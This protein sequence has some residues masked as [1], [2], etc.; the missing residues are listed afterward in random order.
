M[1]KAEYI[2]ILPDNGVSSIKYKQGSQL[3]GLSSV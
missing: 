1:F 3:T 2:L